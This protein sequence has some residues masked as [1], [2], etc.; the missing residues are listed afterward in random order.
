MLLHVLA[1]V[2]VV[3]K[4][5]FRRFFHPLLVG[6]HGHRAPH[7]KVT[8]GRRGSLLNLAF[9]LKSF[10]SNLSE[11]VHFAIELLSW[12]HCVL[13]LDKHLVKHLQ[14]LFALQLTVVFTFT[15]TAYPRTHCLRLWTFTQGTCF[16]HNVWVLNVVDQVTALQHGNYYHVDIF[17]G[18]A[19]ETHV[20][21]LNFMRPCFLRRLQC[22]RGVQ[23]PVDLGAKYLY[24]CV[25]LLIEQLLRLL[26]V[27][28]DS[29]CEKVW[30]DILLSLIFKKKVV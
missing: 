15:F 22:L 3:V 9:G 27:F 29:V 7:F 10:Y 8:R 30:V 25:L 24:F 5:I 18:E 23:R 28:L 13:N 12:L 2:L 19:E 4:I 20:D 26:K 17:R 14:S 1:R 6:R 11:L 16:V 21:C